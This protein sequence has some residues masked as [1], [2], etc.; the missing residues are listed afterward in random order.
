VRAGEL[1]DAFGIPDQVLSAPIGLSEL[2]SRDAGH[3]AR[4]AS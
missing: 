1:V 4:G 3:A 2:A